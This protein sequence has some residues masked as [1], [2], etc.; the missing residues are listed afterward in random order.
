MTI[1]IAGLAAVVITTTILEGAQSAIMIISA[2][3][4]KPRERRIRAEEREAGRAEGREEVRSE[5]RAKTAQ[6]TQAAQA[7]AQAA[8]TERAAWREWYL[9][10]ELAKAKGEEPPPPPFFRSGDNGQSNGQNG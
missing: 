5:E 10:S 4:L 3:F 6:A 9:L 1:G 8:A 7:E 2:T